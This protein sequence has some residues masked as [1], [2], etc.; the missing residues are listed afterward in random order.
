MIP[1]TAGLRSPQVLK[2]K[3]L[4][5]LIK[6][7][8]PFETAASSPVMGQHLY[9]PRWSCTQS[10]NSDWM[11]RF[12]G[13]VGSNGWIHCMELLHLHQRNRNFDRIVVNSIRTECSHHVVLIRLPFHPIACGSCD[14]SSCLRWHLSGTVWTDWST[15]QVLTFQTE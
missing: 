15:L 9:V 14:R 10:S 13:L 11:C 6:L 1:H 4:A 5:W 7:A 2:V 3:L 12:H 8:F